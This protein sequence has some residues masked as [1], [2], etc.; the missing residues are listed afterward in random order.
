MGYAKTS[1]SAHGIHMRLRARAFIISEAERK[2]KLRHA[3]QIETVE[4]LRL[5]KKT[6]QNAQEHHGLASQAD[7]E[8]TICFVSIDIGS[9][10]DLLTVKVLERLQ[11]LLPEHGPSGKRLCH[12]EN[13]S[14]RQVFPVLSLLKLFSELFLNFFTLHIQWHTYSF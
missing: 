13:L 9:G 3:D 10:S 1:Q 6:N 12:L 14:V 4:R 2:D 7:P 5:R 11:E 8:R